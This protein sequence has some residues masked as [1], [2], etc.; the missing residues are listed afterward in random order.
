MSPD[1]ILQ[2]KDFA[3]MSAAEIAQAKALIARFV[4]PEDR[5]PTRRF[6]P[7]ATGRAH[8]SAP[9]VSPFAAGAAARST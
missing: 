2:G 1:E 3:Q 7:D 6:A 8:R 9:L 5:T 4:L